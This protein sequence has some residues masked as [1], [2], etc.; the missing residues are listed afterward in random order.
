MQQNKYK[1]MSFKIYNCIQGPMTLGF[2][3]KNDT[4]PYQIIK[5]NTLEPINQ[6]QDDYRIYHSHKTDNKKKYWYVDIDQSI[7]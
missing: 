5:W 7:K 6:Y 2:K 4:R 1:N 3:N